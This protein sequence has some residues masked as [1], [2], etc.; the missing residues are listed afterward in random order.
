MNSVLLWIGGLLVAA[1][2]LLFAV[3]HAIDWNAYRGVF[4]EEASRV[5]GREVRVGGEVNLRLLPM[6]YVRFEKVRI[7]EA[8]GTLGEPFFRTEAFTLWLAVPP[9]LKGVIEANEVELDRP[10]L[11]LVLNERGQGNWQ[12]FR[13]SPGLLPFVPNDVAL[14]SVRIRD[15]TLSL[16]AGGAAG[17]S[18]LTE[19]NGEF[20][21]SALEGP[22]KF[23]GDALWNGQAREIRVST[24]AVEPDGKLRFKLTVHVN[25]NG[26]SYTLDGTLAE[27]ARAARIDGDLTAQL[28]LASGNGRGGDAAVFDLRSTLAADARGARLGDLALSYERDGRPQLVN[29]EAQAAWQTRLEVATRLTSRWLDLDRITGRSS[30]VSPLQSAR[31][32]AQAITELVPAEGTM[33]GILDVEQVQLGGDTVSGLRIALER[34]AGALKVQEF[35][36]A[37]PGNARLDLKGTILGNDAR[38]FAGDLMLR[39][40]SLPRFLAW[41]APGASSEAGAGEGPFWLASRLSLSP[42]HIEIG[43]ASAEI[44]GAQVQGDLRY[45]WDGGRELAV[46][47]DGSSID[48]S[49]LAPGLL[50]AGQLASLLVP[51]KGLASR[52]EVM[53]LRIRADEVVDGATKFTDVDAD[54]SLNGS[55]LRMPVLKFTSPH[56]LRVEMQGDVKDAG[57]RPVG[58]LRGFVSAPTAEAVAAL[59]GLVG[60]AGP[61]PAQMLPSGVSAFD[62]AFSAALGDRNGSRLTLRSDGMVQDTRASATIVLDGGLAGWREAP[63]DATV[64]LEGPD[65]VRLL[66][67]SEARRGERSP[68]SAASLLLKIAGPSAASLVTLAQL[69]AG[70]GK[71]TFRGRSGL[72][73]A[74]ALDVSGEIGVAIDDLGEVQRLIDSRRRPRVAGIGIDGTLDIAAKAKTVRLEP[75]GLAIGK[76]KVSGW[77]S[78]APGDQNLRIDGKLRASEASVQ[79]LLGLLLDGRSEGPTEAQA[80]EASP[81]PDVA[82][83]FANLDGIDGRLALSVDALQVADRIGLSEAELALELAPGRVKIAKLEGRA[84]GGR[85]TSTMSLERAPAGASLSLSGRLEGLR[86]DE[87]GPR[88]GAEPLAKGSA[89]VSLDVQGRA[90]S[91]RGLLAAASGKGE[92]QI[93]D[94]RISGMAA[95]AVD[96]AAD[97]VLA[98]AT[99]GSR[100]TL[101]RELR[102]AL[103][104]GTL[105]IG[106]RK[107]ALEV[108][109]GAVR[110]GALVIDGPDGRVRNATT[111]DLQELRVDS[112]WQIMSKRAAGRAPPAAKAQL[113]GVLLVYV[114]PLA[115]IG[116]LKPRLS[117]DSLERELMVR[118]MEREVEQLERLRRQDEDRVR[119]PSVAPPAGIEPQVLEAPFPIAPQ[120]APGG[121]TP[122]GAGSQPRRR[123]SVAPDPPAFPDPG[124]FSQSR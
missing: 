4:E 112:E 49:A 72:D 48:L 116:T 99:E 74:G 65:V 28:R 12:T 68:A 43:N 59:G 14:K 41:A 70:A 60:S 108:A 81:W 100:T 51:G 36:A 50:N 15:G 57:G 89:T 38:E 62:L 85:F 17:T 37:L 61:L 97:A 52:P 64:R 19:V 105:M 1:L 39:G 113:P 8:D 115:S 124:S 76:A 53:K 78:L 18:S 96:K 56:G 111:I 54:I 88:R 34:S 55:A 75:R 86:L 29:G 119:A 104:E 95:G 20:S 7:A 107:L 90:L 45:K 114:G 9:L 77:L 110:V 71:V 6:P 27:L 121:G 33:R 23:R 2:A 98:G 102:S 123:Q 26:N 35:K 40:V 24:S 83:A 25:G 69:D 42:A 122:G 120:V 101:E 3:P 91:P 93:V 16:K 117:L 44:G 66:A 109:D 87:V 80:Q 84:L 67:G 118:R 30:D 73:A 13:L 32:L 11:R 22:Y 5:L 82:F 46:T 103:D 63:I 79:R 94:G 106:T 31:V 10:V 58:A 47:V 92:A 21:A